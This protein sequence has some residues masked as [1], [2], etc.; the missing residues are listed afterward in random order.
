M[1][2]DPYLAPHPASA[3]A[4]QLLRFPIRKGSAPKRQ[5][6]PSCPGTVHGRFGRPAVRI[7]P[8][9]SVPQDLGCT[10]VTGQRE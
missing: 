6:G 1:R 7:H 8:A 3:Q 9:A 4:N 2:V 10:T 5:T